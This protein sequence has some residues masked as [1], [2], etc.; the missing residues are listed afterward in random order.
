MT[1]NPLLG[2][3]AL[4]ALVSLDRSGARRGSRAVVHGDGG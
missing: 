4:A 3:V 1:R 2:G